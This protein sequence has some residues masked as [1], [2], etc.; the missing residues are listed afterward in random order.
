MVAH[1][2]RFVRGQARAKRDIAV[3]VYNHYLSQAW[4]DRHGTDLGVHH[5]LMLGPTGSGKTYIVKTL[6]RYLGVPFSINSAASLVESGYRGRSVDDIVSPLLDQAGDNPTQAE[7]GIIFLDEIDKIRRQDSGG[8]DVSGEGVQNALLT[9]LDGRVISNIDMRKIPP[10]N[11]RRILFVCTGAFVGL[12]K[13]VE[14]RLRPD[15]LIGFHARPNERMDEIPDS[16]SFRVLCEAQ[17]ADLVEFGM[18]PE[19]IGRFATIT[20]L[21]EL[22]RNDLRAIV[23]ESTE[24]S[25]LKLQQQLAR[26]HG[27]DLVISDDALD[28]VTDEARAMGT[29]ARG[30]HRLIGR[31]VDS[32]DYRW[33]ELADQGIGRVVIGRDCILGRG[34]PELI[35]CE[36]AEARVDDTLRHESLAVLPRTPSPV[37]PHDAGGDTKVAPGISNT[38]GWTDEQIWNR[39]EALKRSTLQWESTSGAARKWWDAFEASNQHRPALVLRLVEE[40]TIRNA[41]ITEFFLAYVYSNTDNI[42]ANLHY[43]D[44][45]RLKKAADEAKPPPESET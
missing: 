14:R 28:A 26:L 21:H 6:A 31:A 8:R 5:I 25:P 44:Y 12:E 2:D 11:T 41:T 33:P 27:I 43:L 17:T 4:F 7:R 15:R 20:A 30:L 13:L 36:P 40:L 10:I 18:I 45:K 19:F 35:V 34:E 3:S 37:L 38:R 23:S 39:V 29:G 16:D 42:Q 1:L 32:V 22:S 24:A 9:M